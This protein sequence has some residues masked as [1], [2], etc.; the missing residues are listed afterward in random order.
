MRALQAVVLEPE[1]APFARSF[2]LAGST[3]ALKRF[4]F[5]HLAPIV[6]DVVAAGLSQ[7]IQTVG[8]S[9]AAYLVPVPHNSSLGNNH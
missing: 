2:N 7:W 5:L 9:A 8:Q 3:N 6:V 4:A 1:I